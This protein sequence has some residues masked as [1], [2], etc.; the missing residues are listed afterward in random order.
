L[1]WVIIIVL[2]LDT[3]GL[4]ITV[5]IAGSTALFVG[6]GLGLQDT[7]KDLVAGVVILMERTLAA[8]DIVEVSSGLVGRVKEVGLRTTLLETR[9]DIVI[10]VPNQ[11]MTSQN[12][13]N[14]TQ[15][16]RAVRFAIEVGVAYGSDVRLVEQLLI[17]CAKKHNAV[18]KKPLPAVHF[19]NF[20][21]SSLDFKLLFYSSELFR[22]EKIKSDLRFM[23]DQAFRDNN[24]TIPFP[25][26][27]V[28]LRTPLPQEKDEFPSS[29][30]NL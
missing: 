20:G 23:I 22:I 19:A 28:W 30:I 15:N 12:V 25:Q 18:S 24:I 13:I 5:L 16:R 7:F 14:W 8:D 2:A 11:K 10:V 29:I 4:P 1:A 26:Q 27:D 17:E 3:I 6:L 9:E 21:N